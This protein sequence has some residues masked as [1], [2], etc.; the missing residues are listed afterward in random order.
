M[1]GK[2]PNKKRVSSIPCIFYFKLIVKRGDS[3]R[4]ELTLVPKE[5]KDFQG[6]NLAGFEMWS[7]H[8][9]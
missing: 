7:G 8:F 3:Y 4:R 6:Q 2:C 5:K 9:A 1:K